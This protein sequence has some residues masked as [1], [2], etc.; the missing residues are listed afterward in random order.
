MEPFLPKEVIYRPKTGFGV[1]LRQ[2]LH[3]D[4][5]DMVAETL[6]RDVVHTRGHFDPQAV[7]NLVAADRSKSIDGSYTIFA[8][9]SFELWCRDVLDR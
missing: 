8:L 7:D 9:M 4:L 5:S 6:S 3:N 1:P 2:W